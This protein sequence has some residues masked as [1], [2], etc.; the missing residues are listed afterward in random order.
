MAS[1]SM[2]VWLIT[3][4]F[5]DPSETFTCNDVLALK[6]TGMNVIVHGLRPKHPLCSQLAL[7]RDVAGIWITHNS[8]INTLCG[9]WIGLTQ[10]ILLINFISWISRHTWKRPVNLLKSLLLVPRSLQI[11]ESAK[12]EN[13]DV[14]YLYWSHFPSLVGY[15][16]QTRLPQIVVSTSFV[17]YDLYSPEYD[18]KY[19]YSSSV[20]RNADLVQTVAAANFPAIEKY[21]IAKEKILLSYHGINFHKIPSRAGK[22]KRR[23]VTAGRLVPEKGFDDV[24]HTFSKVLNHWP[25]ASL[26]ILGDGPERKKLEALAKSLNIC[27]SVDFRGFVPH[28]SIFEEMALS[29]VFLFLSQI[30][31]LP[32]VVK[33]AMACYCLC[34]V[35][36]TL[37]IE[38]LILDKVSG[39]VLQQNDIDTAFEQIHRAFSN[40]MEM[41]KMT[42]LAFAHLKAKFDI[43]CIAQVLHQSWRSLAI[44]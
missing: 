15:L 11:Y 38:E 36:H 39:Y 37:G 30:E 5:P 32:N 2:K 29:E 12:Q 25:D 24:L 9:L 6:R 42:E 17:A 21:G 43:D 10:P 31:R 3:M 18:S 23:I 44:S 20:A 13:P 26:V 8:I 22:I 33:E 14:I 34:I 27:H 7:E 28:N 16:I 41:K 4:A 1:Q 40:S 19:F 35:S